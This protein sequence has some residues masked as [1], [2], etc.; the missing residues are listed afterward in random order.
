MININSFAVS[1]KAVYQGVSAGV[2]HLLKD[3]SNFTNPEVVVNTITEAVMAHLCEVFDFGIQP[4]RFTPDLLRKIQ[5]LQER[6]NPPSPPPT[7]R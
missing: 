2:E 5:E 1:E 4:V 3:V 6:Q 7:S